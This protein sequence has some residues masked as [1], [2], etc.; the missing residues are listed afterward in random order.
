MRV[1]NQVKIPNQDNQNQTE[2]DKTQDVSQ[3][4]NDVSGNK[5]DHEGQKLSLEDMKKA[6]LLEKAKELERLASKNYD[7]FIR[8]QAEIENLKKR[9][10]KEKTDLI[11][12]SNE[13]LIKQLLAVVD[14]LEKAIL[15]ATDETSIAAVRQ[16]IE[17]TLKS[18]M[19]TLEKSGL[20]PVAAEGE[21]FDP[22]YHEA[23]S[24]V[25]DDNVKP[26]TVVRVLQKGYTLNDRLIRPAMVVVS[27]SSGQGSVPE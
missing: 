26:G 16:G 3:E 7:L 25:A 14:N 13:S 6:Q 24:E 21:P 22:N 10:Q 20:K 4:T 11:K 5:S 12:F 23:I 1:V 17:W 9:F 8:S 18:L 27:K 2:K 15:A 19:D